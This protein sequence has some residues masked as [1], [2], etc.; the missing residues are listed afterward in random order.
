MRLQQSKDRELGIFKATGEATK[1]F[2]THLGFPL[3]KVD[4]GSAKDEAADLG[5]QA[6]NRG[7]KAKAGAKKAKA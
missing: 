1:A 2:L 3:K 7:G 4:S 6:A 5:A